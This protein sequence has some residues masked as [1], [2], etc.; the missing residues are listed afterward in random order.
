MK[1][2]IEPRSDSGFNEWSADAQADYLAQV[3]GHGFNIALRNPH[4]RA[5]WDGLDAATQ[6]KIKPLIGQAVVVG[7]IFGSR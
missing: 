3:E 5:I 7:Y 6:K 1:K 4:F 2:P